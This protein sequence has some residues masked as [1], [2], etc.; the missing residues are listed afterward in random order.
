[1]EINEKNEVAWNEHA[2]AERTLNLLYFQE[3]SSIKIKDK[4]FNRIISAHLEYLY[5]SKNYKSNNHGLMMDRTLLIGSYYSDNSHFRER[6]IDIF[7]IFIYR[8]FST[9]G[10]YLEN[11]PEY[12]SFTLKLIHEFTITLQALNIKVDKDINEIIKK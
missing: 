1:W 11:S 2:V 4:K 8:N 3:N 10:I 7:Y 12:H 6:A 9:A 5:D